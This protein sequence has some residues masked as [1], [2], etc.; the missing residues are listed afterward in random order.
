[1][2]PTPS[3]QIAKSMGKLPEMKHA[4]RFWETNQDVTFDIYLR[5]SKLYYWFNKWL[6]QLQVISFIAQIF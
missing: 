4:A 6:K 2:R 3:H 1:M 5:P